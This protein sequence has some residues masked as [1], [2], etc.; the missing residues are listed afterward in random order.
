MEKNSVRNTISRLSLLK[1]KNKILNLNDIEREI[2]FKELE[3]ENVMII[4]QK[5]E[6]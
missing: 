3:D 1:E 2:K 4:C 6:I 5:K